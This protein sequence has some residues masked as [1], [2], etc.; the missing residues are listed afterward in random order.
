MRIKEPDCVEL[1]V[2]RAPDWGS[3]IIFQTTLRKWM[4]VRIYLSRLTESETWNV[5]L[6]VLR[7]ADMS[8]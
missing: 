1:S 6:G 2:N 3:E 4:C 7:D 5:N 8:V